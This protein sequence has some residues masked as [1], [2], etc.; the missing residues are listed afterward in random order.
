M[1]QSSAEKTSST[2]QAQKTTL[3]QKRMFTLPGLEQW[4][5]LNPKQRLI[6]L[7]VCGLLLIA[8]TVGALQLFMKNPAAPK[9]VSIAP[10]TE[11]SKP[12]T[13]PSPLTG[14]QVTPE[15]AALPVTGVMI[16][17]SPDA[18]PQSGLNSAGVVF[19]A[20][21]EGGITRFLALYQEDQ[22]DYIGPVRSVRPYY[23]DFLVPFDA[24]L[25]HAGGS[26]EALAQ[27]REQGLKDL[28]HGANGGAYQ[29]VSNR[30]SPHNLYTSRAQL[31]EL[32]N[33]KGFTTSN[34]TGWPRKAQET[35]LETPTIGNISFNISGQLYNSTYA[36]D[37]ASN[38]Y[39]RHL[40]G[41]PHTDERSGEQIS[42]KVVIA[43]ITNRSQT[44]IYSVYQVT[45]SG[46]VLIF[47][48]GGVAEGTWE[49]AGR[50]SQFVFKAPDG[51][52][53][54]LNPG[55]TWVTL[56]TPGSV[57]HGP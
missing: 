35:P 50:A 42:P 21:S 28:D 11:P 43:I 15:L 26:A 14:V 4:K 9:P 2:P 31:L 29:R 5:Q 40:A 30:Y 6:S 54:E 7:G 19:E 16:E 51:K 56:A 45:G 44:G 41:R 52:P 8:A 20:I 47:Q 33:Q 53:L 37:K 24:P 46:S 23:L 10:K 34:F 57:Q 25:A 49:K 12:T 18:R 38:S 3:K 36:Y 1:A 55:R 22:P 17:N 39:K 27:I 48:D 32:H 13:T